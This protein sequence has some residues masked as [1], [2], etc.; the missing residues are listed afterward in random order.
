MKI[1]IF[2]D[3][4]YP[5]LDG[6]V[7]SITNSMKELAKKGHEIIIFAPNYKNKTVIKLHPNIT[8][9]RCFSFSLLSYKEVKISIPPILKVIKKIKQFK[10]DIIH[11]HTPGTIGLLGIFCSKFYEI[12]SI[13]TYH[14]II[15]EQTTYLS[16]TRL[17]NLDKLI[18]IIKSKSPGIMLNRGS[19]IKSKLMYFTNKEV[20]KTIIDL[21]T[22]KIVRNKKFNKRVMWKITCKFYNKCD[23]II[24]PSESI[25]KGLK[26]YK[27]TKP[28]KVLSN[29]VN[30]NRFSPKKNYE[31]GRVFKIIH[32]GRVGFE[33]NIDVIVRSYNLLLKEKENVSL[34]IVGDGPAILSLKNLVKSLGLTN[35]IIFTGYMGG[36]K[37]VDEYKSGDI[38]VTASTMETQGLTILEAMSCGLPIVGVNEYAIPDLVIHNVN[39]YVAKP[40]DEVKIKEYLLKLMENPPLMKKFGRKSVEIAK[41]HDLKKVVNKLEGLYK[42]VKLNIVK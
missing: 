37:L 28:I 21:I 12:P 31:A 25:I 4:F 35:K 24:V 9:Y 13:G 29:G 7:T 3:T 34:D 2:T 11:L 6:I 42:R 17:T 40:F 10:P 41:T 33:K 14:T 1:A 32:V 19:Y 36:K 27:V 20:I 23:L 22:F 38:F 18:E 26:E 39:G 8:V 30:L 5:K 15:S 16:L